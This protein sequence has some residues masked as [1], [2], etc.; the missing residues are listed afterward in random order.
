MYE[1]G[2]CVQAYEDRR[3]WQLVYLIDGIRFQWHMPSKIV[4]WQVEEKR[5]PV[6]FEYVKGLPRRTKPL[7]ECIALLEWVL[8]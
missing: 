6:R 2:L 8:S 4:T 5:A 3:V 7:A 1:K